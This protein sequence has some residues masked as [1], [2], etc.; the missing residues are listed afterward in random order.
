MTAG[1][2]IGSVLDRPTM[3][4]LGLHPHPIA[5][6]VWGK[7]FSGVPMVRWVCPGT[8]YALIRDDTHVY[9]AGPTVTVCPRC[10]VVVY[11]DSRPEHDRLL[12][13]HRQDHRCHD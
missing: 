12:S 2:P 6:P 5:V 10:A 7:D 3:D 9:T 1:D 8:T 13:E 4:Y 11:G